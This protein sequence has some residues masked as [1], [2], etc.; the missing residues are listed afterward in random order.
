MRINDALGNPTSFSLTPGQKHD[1]DGADQLLPDLE[2]GIIIA[3]KGYDVDKRVIEPLLRGGTTPVIPL[4]NH[5][6]KLRAYGV[7]RYKA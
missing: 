6:E 5:R 4:R 3:D 7:E 2:A 1:L